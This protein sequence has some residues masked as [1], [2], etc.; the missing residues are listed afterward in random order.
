MRKLYKQRN[1]VE[2][3]K[4][5]NQLDLVNSSIEQQAIKDSS[6]NETPKP[7]VKNIRPKTHKK[8]TIQMTFGLNPIEWKSHI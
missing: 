4:N 6:P 5:N 7:K 1:I 2:N 3:L 8:P